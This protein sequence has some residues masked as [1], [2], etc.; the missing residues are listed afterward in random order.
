MQWQPIS[1]LKLTGIEVRCAE[2]WLLCC[3]FVP[4]GWRW[5]KKNRKGVGVLLLLGGMY[6]DVFFFFLV[7]C[8]FVP[9]LN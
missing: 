9:G 1:G 3:C 7:I 2:K 5:D 6:L 4:G 8:V